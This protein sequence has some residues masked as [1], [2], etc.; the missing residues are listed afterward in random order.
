MYTMLPCPNGAGGLFPCFCVSESICNRKHL[1]SS[2]LQ[3]LRIE[4]ACTAV[5]HLQ[6]QVFCYWYSELRASRNCNMYHSPPVSRMSRDRH[7][8]SALPS[9]TVCY[10]ACSIPRGVPQSGNVRSRALRRGRR[11][12]SHIQ[13][14]AIFHRST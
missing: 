7:V 14:Y 6:E 3:L 10:S 4:Q 11:G 1:C 5:R 9:P 2:Q 13:L 12:N 8:S